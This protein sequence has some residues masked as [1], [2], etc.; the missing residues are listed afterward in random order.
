MSDL[1]IIFSRHGVT[2]KDAVEKGIPYQS[3]YKQLR[4]ERP[5]TAKSAMRIHKLLGIPLWE[6]RPDFWPPE[7]FR[8]PDGGEK[9]KKRTAALLMKTAKNYSRTGTNEEA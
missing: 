4:G 7:F 1:S 3:I 9:G 5:V 2:L 6:M 8:G